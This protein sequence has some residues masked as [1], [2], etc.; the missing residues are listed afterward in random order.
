MLRQAELTNY[1]RDSAARVL[2]TSSGYLAD[3]AKDV[4]A[5]VTLDEVVIAD[6]ATPGSAPASSPRIPGSVPARSMDEI[7]VNGRSYRKPTA[8]TV[9]VCYD[10]CDPRYIS[11]GVLAGVFPNF[12]P[13]H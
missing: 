8:P 6:P 9:V 11:H 1:L 13:A 12:R 4:L 7:T 10:G 5:D 3:V 2:V